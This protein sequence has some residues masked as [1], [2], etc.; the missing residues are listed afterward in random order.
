MKRMGM[1]RPL[2]SLEDKLA[3]LLT[4]RYK[5]IARKLLKDIK[6]QVKQSGLTLDCVLVTD[7]AEDD[8]MQS[9]MDFF[10]R[11]G[12]EMQD[13]QKR[14]ANQSNM[15][16]VAKTLEQ[17]WFDKD[18]DELDRLDEQ[19]TG[20]ID[21]IFKKEQGDFLERLFDDSDGLTKH[22]IQSFTIDKKKFF[23]AN[24][25]EI[26]RLYIDNS[27][28]RIKGE[29]NYIKMKV[30]ERITDYALGKTEELKLDDLTKLAFD[31]GQHMARLFARD[32]MARFNKA[33]TLGTFKS[34]N[35]TKVQ[36]IT[37]NDGRVRKS[38]KA[39]NKMIF[40]INNLPPEVDDYNCRCGLIPV[41]WADD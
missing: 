32:Q 22:I 19:F 1:P 37:A 16:F 38:H 21:K 36:W 26:R 13:E 28:E 39:L 11:M 30:L 34:A 29:Q 15:G 14:I 10:E 27:L 4:A 17:E 9:L 3:R 35:V 31:T 2:F 6:T 5:V 23:E 18:Q 40:D 33:C 41:E 20:D 24:M 25:D 12:K 8:N 7:G